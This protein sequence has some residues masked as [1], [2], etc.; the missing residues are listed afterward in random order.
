MKLSFLFCVVLFL[1]QSCTGITYESDSAYQLPVLSGSLESLVYIDSSP[2]KDMDNTVGIC[3]KR[4]V[5]DRDLVINIP[6][7]NYAYN[8]NVTCSKSIGFSNNYDV[9]KK[10][11]FN[12]KINAGLYGDEKH[13][14]C[15][16]AI[17][18]MDRGVVSHK[19]EIRVRL[20]DT[21]Y[22]KRNAITIFRENNRTFLIL[23]QYAK[24]VQVFKNDKWKFY[25]KKT[26]LKI[27]EEEVNTIKVIS[28]SESGR[29]N[30]YNI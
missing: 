4:L 1:L 2:C 9:P 10:S 14:I 16:G 19:F 28:E 7:R 20:V 27:K 18:P 26:V 29:L 15:I 17:A 11:E 3:S 21:D 30:Y 23:G 25:K 13:F 6:P 24:Y 12:I 8:V 5:R 22:I